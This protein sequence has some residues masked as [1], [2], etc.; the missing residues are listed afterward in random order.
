MVLLVG[1]TGSFASGK[2]FTLNYLSSVGFAIFSADSY[3]ADL[4]TKSEIR[5]RVLEITDL[6][7]FDK[8]TLAQI[9]Y[10]DKDKMRAIEEFIHPFVI[11]ELQSFKNQNQNSNFIFAE[12]PLLFESNFDK[13]V[14]FTV[15]T[16]CAEDTRLNRAKMRDGFNQK[17]YN[18]IQAI[19]FSQNYKINQSD[20]A[21]NTDRNIIEF[22]SQV[23][24]LITQCEQRCVK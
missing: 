15:T 8:A 16:F 14:D 24:Q 19:Q 22:E 4:Y 23:R 21:I 18:Q 12:I 2:S 11:K 5:E 13:Y 6:K 17:I 9:I 20:I 3:V 10:N 1:I 7:K